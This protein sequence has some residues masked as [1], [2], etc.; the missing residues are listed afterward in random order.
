MKKIFRM[1][2]EKCVLSMKKGLR[3]TPLTRCNWSECGKVLYY[4]MRILQKEKGGDVEKA[5]TV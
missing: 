2:C 3:G 4:K 1:L 5:V